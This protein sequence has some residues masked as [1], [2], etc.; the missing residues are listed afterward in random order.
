MSLNSDVL[1]NFITHRVGTLYPEMS[2][3]EKGVDFFID[4][5]QRDQLDENV[6]VTNLEKSVAYFETVYPVHLSD[7][8][9]DCPSFMADHAKL[10]AAGLDYVTIEVKR[11]KVLMDAKGESSEVISIIQQ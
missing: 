5:L 10:L 9:T 8:R 4:L 2:V 6:P 3:Y 7:Q 11:I 1:K